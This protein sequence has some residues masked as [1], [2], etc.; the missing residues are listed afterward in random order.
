[1]TDS[2]KYSEEEVYQKLIKIIREV[3]PLKVVGEITLNTSLVEDFAFDSIDMMDLLLKIQEVFMREN[4]EPINLNQFISC[5]YN[6]PNGRAVTVRS[7]CSM[8]LKNLYEKA[9]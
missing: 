3:A 4:A 6:N 5:A 1:M 2:K 9:V 7:V 8:I